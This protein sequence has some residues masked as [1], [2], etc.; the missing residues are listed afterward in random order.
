ME[1][2]EV[3]DNVI[4]LKSL[5]NEIREEREKLDKATKSLDV[6]EET[7]TSKLEEWKEETGQAQKNFQEDVLKE[8]DHVSTKIGI[9]AYEGFSKHF[10]E[11]THDSIQKLNDLSSSITEAFAETHKKLKLRNKYALFYLGGAC[12]FGALIGS[13]AGGMVMRYFPKFDDYTEARYNWG[14]ALDLSWSEL[15]K[16]EQ[17]K[18]KKLIK[19]NTF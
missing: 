19:K 13:V 16:S 6:L 4:L 10:L 15:S 3:K 12:L 11:T 7:F 1:T 9:K 8:L 5:S 2:D 17:E 14:R 18:L